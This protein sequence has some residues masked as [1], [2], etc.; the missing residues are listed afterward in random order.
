MNK[1][2]AASGTRW[3]VFINAGDRLCADVE[4]ESLVRGA[5]P[6]VDVIDGDRLEP[7][8]GPSV[9]RSPARPDRRRP[10]SW[11]V[12]DASTASDASPAPRP[13]CSSGAVPVPVS[14]RASLIIRPF[15]QIVG[16]GP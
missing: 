10:G 16:E 2:V 12:R 1:G 15:S 5:R 14:R 11:F 8:A 9:L 7:H 13:S 3:R 6:S 4:L